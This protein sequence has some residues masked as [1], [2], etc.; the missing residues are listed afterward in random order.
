MNFS[1]MIFSS[2]A[3]EMKNF[4]LEIF[5]LVETLED[6]NPQINLQNFYVMTIDFIDFLSEFLEDEIRDK[7]VNLFQKARITLKYMTFQEILDTINDWEYK[8]Y[9]SNVTK[10]D[11]T[12]IAEAIFYGFHEWKNEFP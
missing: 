3:E 7:L 10:A 1:L 5:K 4:I 9:P 12:L 6:F 8:D 2:S 11:C